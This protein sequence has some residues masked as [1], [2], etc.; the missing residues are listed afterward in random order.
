VSSMSS[1]PRHAQRPNPAHR[2]RKSGRH[3]AARPSPRALTGSGSHHLK[4]VRI[5]STLGVCALFATAGSTAAGFVVRNTPVHSEVATTVRLPDVADTYVSYAAKGKNYAASLRISASNR[6][7]DRKVGYLRFQIP[8]ALIPRVESAHLILTRDDHHL[9]GNVSV[10]DVADTSWRPA[11]V[12]ARNAPALGQGL[13]S[14]RTSASTYRMSFDVLSAVRGRSRL[15]LAVTSSSTND[16]ARFRSRE[17]ATGRPELVLVLYGTEP[18]PP[19]ALPGPDP[20]DSSSAS[21]TTAPPST[22]PGSTSHPAP[23]TQ[24]S[25]STAAPPPA[26]SPGPAPAP[27]DTL[28]GDTPR[29]SSSAAAVA[30]MDARYGSAQVVR[31]FWSGA[32]RP[33]PVHGRPVVGSIKRI[34]AGTAAWASTMWRWTYEHEIDS[35]IKKGMTTLAEWR[36]SMDSLVALKVPGLSVI[37]TADAFVSRSKNPS[38]FLV[39]GV[40]HLG[41]DF[42]GISQSGGY[43]DYSRELAAVEAFTRAHH[44]TWGVAEFGA[45]RASNDP[46]GTARAAWLKT[47]GERFAAAG[48]EYVC[49][50]EADSQSG[51]DFTTPAET[52][53]VRQLF[54]R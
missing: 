48:A 20:G 1:S 37:L 40:T 15:A 31:L 8:A 25:T 26:T 30:A 22:R 54:A 43:H 45:N 46:S 23:P 41:V 35:K 16:V 36:R 29:S 13:A 9:S 18:A 6:P 24:P 34:D 51:S 32:A 3:A 2:Y 38:D 47:W 44:L 19:I 52:A 49:L 50:W 4:H 14:A 10:S 33:S 27:L 12:T 17:A 5:F 21:A 39:P 28:F 11:A 7:S 42:D 53:A